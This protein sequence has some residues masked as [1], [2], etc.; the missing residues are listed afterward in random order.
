M[1]CCLERIRNQ[2]N[3]STLPGERTMFTAQNKS[4]RPV[5]TTALVR[6]GW[7][8]I[9]TPVRITP[10][11]VFKTAAF[12]R[13]ATHPKANGRVEL[14]GSLKANSSNANAWLSNVGLLRGSCRA[15]DGGVSS[16]NG[17]AAP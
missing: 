12:D 17:W 10:K 2:H 13:S 15:A 8:G 6:S 11:A 4:R 1:G 7:G 14:A 9:R 5:T 3:F 16:Q